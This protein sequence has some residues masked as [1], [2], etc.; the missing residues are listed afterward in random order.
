MCSAGGRVDHEESADAGLL[1]SGVSRLA[2][3]GVAEPALEAARLLRRA[4]ELGPP[5]LGRQA[6][7]RM[8]AQRERHMPL[9]YIEGRTTF[10]GRDFAVDPRVQVT[11]PAMQ[12][13]VRIGATMVERVAATRRQPQVPVVDVGTGSGALAIML[14]LS[15]DAAQPVYAT[16]LSPHALDVATANV[17]AA[18]LAERIVLREGSL[19]DPVPEPIG[20][21]MANLP[22]VSQGMRDLLEPGVAEYEPSMAVFGAGESGWS[23]QHE[24]LEQVSR[25]ADRPDAIIVTF[26]VSQE[27]EA[28]AAAASFTGYEASVQELRPGWSGVLIL[29][30][31][32]H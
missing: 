23:L 14:A 3:A 31:L 7:N 9:E 20:L 10:M 21:V 5:D 26:H 22:F 32:A 15:Q 27:E 13:F 19:L 24:L 25:R 6:F 1:R 11:R 17:M 28:M 12:A 29:A 30:R 8:V 4:R 2:A 16:D 18:G